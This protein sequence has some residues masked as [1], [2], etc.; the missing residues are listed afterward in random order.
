VIGGSTIPAGQECPSDVDDGIN[1][2]FAHPNIAPFLSRQL[3][4]RFT[5]SSPSPAYIQRVA[6]KFLGNGFGERGDLSAV[7][8]QVL[9][10]PEA[11]NAPTTNSGKPRE[12]MLRLTAMWRAWDAQMPVADSYGNI[13][14]GMTNP[15]GTFGQRPLGADTVFN[16]FEPDY[17]QPGIIADTG[18]Y[19]PEFQT[20]NESTLTSASNSYYTYSWNSYV[21]MSS[22]P[23]NRPL[24]NLAPLVALASDPAAMVEEVNKRMMYGS[25]STNM[26][27]VLRNMLIFMDGASAIDKART[28]VYVTAL[29]PE[30]AVQR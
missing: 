14:M 7:I 23:S 3:I 19:S 28:V 4:Q 26:Q 20:L 27:S 10:D 11:R 22:P 29:S 17:Q 2:R 16:F 18:L 13:A 21:G 5:S 6:Q 30:Y 15:S 12:P 9:M 1:L 25:M 8:R 24:L